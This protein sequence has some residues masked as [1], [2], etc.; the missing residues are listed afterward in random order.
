MEDVLRVYTQLD[1]L[2]SIKDGFYAV[3]QFMSILYE[4]SKST[5]ARTLATSSFAKIV[6]EDD[7]RRVLKVK[8]YINENFMHEIRLP[9]LADMAGLNVLDFIC[10]FILHNRTTYSD[11]IFITTL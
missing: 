6:I 9:I 10:F 4:I 5:T 11:F 7:S 2:S 3:S 8:N 1:T